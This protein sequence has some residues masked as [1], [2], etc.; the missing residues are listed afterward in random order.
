MAGDIWSLGSVIL[1][2]FSHTFRHQQPDIYS[3]QIQEGV[4]PCDTHKLSV[5]DTQLP[6]LVRS[7]LAYECS[8]RPSAKFVFE[9][10]P[11]LRLHDCKIIL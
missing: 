2:L 4:S 9:S 3:S 6:S 11:N 7:M 1:S 5:D 10:L 8:E